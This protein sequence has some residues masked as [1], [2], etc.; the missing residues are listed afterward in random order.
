MG[1]WHL[2]DLSAATGAPPARGRVA[3]YVFDAQGTQHV[4]F[5]SA[6]TIHELW[7]DSNGW[8]RNDL[9][10]A[11]GAPHAEGFGRAGYAFGA[12]GTQ[13]VF[14]PGGGHIHELWWNS[15]GWH[16]NDLT[17]ATGA[18]DAASSDPDAYVFDAQ[19]TQ[20]L[21][22]VGNATARVHELWWDTTGW[23]H[24]DLTATTGAPLTGSNPRGYVFGAQRTQHVVYTALNQGRVQEL[25]WD[26]HGWH[27]NDL[28]A[29]TG[30]PT[31]VSDLAGYVF[32]SQGTQHVVY[33]AGTDASHLQGIHELWWDTHGWHHNDLTGAASAPPPS[34]AEPT[35]YA[36]EAEGTQHVVYPGAD[37][38]IHELW[39]DNHGWHHNDL[40]AAAAAPEVNGLIGNT[41]TGYAFENQG[42]QH[43][44]YVGPDDHV[45]ELWW[46]FTV[47]PG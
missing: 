15:N 33:L 17:A 25:W 22:Y 9:T 32:D 42:T 14:Y 19:G 11:T 23:H 26:T 30:A 36:F 1:S 37:T 10:A 6:G 20:H 44:V 24:T 38:H 13:H 12:Q 18:P 35:A 39:W 21:I 47:L 45:Y 29:A 41:L 2:N 16:H 4:V 27:H 34:A 46:G 3:G 43:V 28:T 8:H 7:W 5:N 31:P 40:T